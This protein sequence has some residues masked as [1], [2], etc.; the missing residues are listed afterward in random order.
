M[1]I[2]A[3]L[4]RLKSKKIVTDMDFKTALYRSGCDE[5]TVQD[6]LEYPVED[7]QLL[8]QYFEGKTK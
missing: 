8:I 3:T 4:E 2:L 6:A 1:D 5:D 7:R